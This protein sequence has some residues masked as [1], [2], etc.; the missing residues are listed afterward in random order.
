[1]GSGHW[2]INSSIPQPDM[3]FILLTTW[4]SMIGG[5]W[6]L[7]NTL[8]KW[9]TTVR[10]LPNFVLIL[11]KSIINQIKYLISTLLSKSILE[12]YFQSILSYFNFVKYDSINFIG[13]TFFFYKIL[14]LL[15]SWFYYTVNCIQWVEKKSSV[16]G[17]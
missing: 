3:R 15:I 4:Q 7:G 16:I 12:C 9:R 11:K 1:M 10:M 2:L 5:L 13:F 14:R 6:W 17:Y 8:V